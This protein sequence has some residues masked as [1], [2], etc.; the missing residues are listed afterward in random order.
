MK[1][2]R[3]ANVIAVWKWRYKPIYM[4]FFWQ[5][6]SL[7]LHHLSDSIY[8]WNCCNQA[9]VLNKEIIMKYLAIKTFAWNFWMQKLNITAT[10]RIV[11]IAKSELALLPLYFYEHGNLVI[12]RARVYVLCKVY[13][14]NIGFLW[15]LFNHND[16]GHLKYFKC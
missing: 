8:I 3:F 11:T 12:A 14:P 10:L 2:I 5:Y 7:N 6:F 1:G 16:K 13:I 9:Q 4:L 15:Y